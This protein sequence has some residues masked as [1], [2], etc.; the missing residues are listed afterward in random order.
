MKS[1][2]SFVLTPNPIYPF[3]RLEGHAARQKNYEEILMDFSYFNAAEV[4]EQRIEEN[5]GL[6]ELD[7]LIRNTYLE[8]LSRFYAVF[9]STHEYAM[10]LRR[11]LDELNRGYHIQQTIENILEDSEGKQLMV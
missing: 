10:D 4:N 7:S 3:Y 8:I 6:Q 5:Q 1:T 11:F 9:E 2:L